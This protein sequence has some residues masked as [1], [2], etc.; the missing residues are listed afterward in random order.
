MSN[1]KKYL[2][3]A[4]TLGTIAMCGGLL[5]GATNLITKERI[6]QNEKNKINNG[7]KDIFGNSASVN[8]EETIDSDF[9]YVT[10]RYLVNEND[11]LTGYAFQTTGSNMYGKISLIIGF[12]AD[13]CIF[14][15]LSIIVNE[16]TYATT[17]VENYINPLNANER[18]YE[19]V[20]CGA[21]YGASLVRDMIDEASKVANIMKGV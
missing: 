6:A 8:K 12:T 1:M 16:Q 21:T 18:D 17:L 4:I 2:I 19:D 7:I 14:K 11:L 9:Q 13:E 15:G 20:S 3:T 5:I 10:K